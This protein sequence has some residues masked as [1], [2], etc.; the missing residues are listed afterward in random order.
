[1]VTNGQQTVELYSLK[2]LINLKNFSFQ[3]KEEKLCDKVDRLSL[4]GCQDLFNNHLSLVI[5][6]RN[7]GSCG[8]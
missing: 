3:F 4:A 5:T 6:Y 8:T 1:M 7:S 2:C